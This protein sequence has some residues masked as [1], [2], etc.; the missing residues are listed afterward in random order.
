M[1]CPAVESSDSDDEDALGEVSDDA[2]NQDIPHRQQQTNRH[3]LPPIHNYLTTPLRLEDILRYYETTRSERQLNRDDSEETTTSDDN[4]LPSCPAPDAG[5]EQPTQRI[6][7]QIVLNRPPSYDGILKKPDPD[8]EEYGTWIHNNTHKYTHVHFEPT[9]TIRSI[10]D[11]G[12]FSLEEEKVYGQMLRYNPHAKETDVTSYLDD[13]RYQN[14]KRRGH[15]TR[16][17]NHGS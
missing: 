10:P 6:R 11:N 9:I 2:S 7:S 12:T 17:T 8:F 15:T 3:P 4:A 14:K 1:A 16:S 5:G 13:E